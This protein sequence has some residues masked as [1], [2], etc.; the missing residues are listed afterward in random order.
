MPRRSA[1]HLPASF[2]QNATDNCLACHLKNKDE[3]VG[4]FQN[5][6]HSRR[7]ISCKE[8][9]GGDATATDKAAAHGQNFIGKPTA[10]QILEMCGACHQP[11]VEIFKKS[12]HFPEK[13]QQSR[14][15]CVQCHGAHTIGKII[16]HSE[17]AVTCTNCHGLEY[18]PALPEPLQK[19]LQMD[20]EVRDALA[21]LEKEGRKPTEEITRQRRELRH[22][23]GDLV[24]ATNTKSATEKAP[25]LLNSGEIL[26]KQIVQARGNR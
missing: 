6:T 3:T 10:P 12:L 17:F 7:H 1:K 14:L 9:H 13:I 16:D 23:I 5:S 2:Q 4:I 21:N 20:D 26:K 8:C 22:Q 25:A 24:H 15:T 18:L 19:I 11:A